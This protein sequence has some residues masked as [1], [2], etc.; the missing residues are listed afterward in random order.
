MAYHE[1]PVH[2]SIPVVSLWFHTHLLGA[3]KYLIKDPF[4]AAMLI[5][6][7]CKRKINIKR[8]NQNPKAIPKHCWHVW[9]LHPGQNCQYN[10]GPFWI[11]AKI[12]LVTKNK[13]QKPLPRSMTVMA[14]SNHLNT[15]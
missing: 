10:Q 5:I 14:S 8:R 1:M 6:A 9:P 7:V 13:K 3:M 15:T 11:L 2:L 12:E 4:Q